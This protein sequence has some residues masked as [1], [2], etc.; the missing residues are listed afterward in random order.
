MFLSETEVTT[1]TG[2]KQ[3]GAQKRWLQKEDI[4]FLE[5]RK[6]RPIVHINAIEFRL[7]NKNNLHKN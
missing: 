4:P 2:L 5:S 1:M 3:F 7:A 6:G